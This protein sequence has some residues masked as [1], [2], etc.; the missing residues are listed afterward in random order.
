MKKIYTLAFILAFSTQFISA[1]EAALKNFRF[2]LKASP[3]FTWLVPDDV[4]QF[5]NA[6]VKVKFNY[7][8]I[9]EFKLTKT[10][11][12]CTGFDFNSYGGKMNFKNNTTRYLVEDVYKKDTTVYYYIG[13]RT[14]NMKTYELPLTLKLRT[15][16]IGSLTY[17]GQFG[18]NF[19]FRGKTKANDEGTYKY[20]VKKAPTSLSPDTLVDGLVEAR[21]DNIV[22]SE[23][24]PIRLGLNVGI[25]AEYN[26]VGSTSV[27]FSINYYN[28]FI[29]N[30]KNKSTT[31][32][33]RTGTV[34]G[35]ITQNVKSNGLVINVGFLF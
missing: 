34:I 6:G 33:S 7:G 14:F 26:L 21:P 23:M 2:G 9:T 17:F 24:S 13:T 12:L 31:L 4:K 29:N 1:Q 5:T 8:L 10:A 3:V 11:V 25:G 27:V 19:G 35:N 32:E 20:V 18:V 22:T 16:E 30:L 28:S 15:P